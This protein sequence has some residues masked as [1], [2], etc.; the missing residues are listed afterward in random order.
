[1][2]WEKGSEKEFTKDGFPKLDLEGHVGEIIPS[3]RVIM[4]NCHDIFSLPSLP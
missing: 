4:R 2:F 3:E 1:M